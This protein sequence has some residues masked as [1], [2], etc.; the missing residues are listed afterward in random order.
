MKALVLSGG[1][2]TRLRPITSTGA[3]QLIPVANRPILFYVLDNVARAGLREVGMIISPETGNE[4]RRVVGSGERWGMNVEYILQDRPGGLAHAVKTA[5]PFLG[6]S[7]FVMYLGD[8]LIG[9]G[10]EAFIAKFESAGCA[11]VILLKEVEDA[12]WFGV[13]ELGPGG[14]VVRLLE[15]PRNPPSNLALVGVYVFSP[16]VHAAIDAIRP[17]ARG[18]LEITDAI[19]QLIDWNLPVESHVVEGWW[20]DTGKKDDLLAANTVVLDQWL[21]SDNQGELDSTSQVTGR[22]KI[23]KGSRLVNSRIRGPA[24][25]GEN[26]LIEDSFIGPYSSIGDGT[27]IRKSVVEHCVVLENCRID[28]IDRLE[29]SVLGK[30]VTVATN[31]GSHRALRLLLGDYSA[32]EL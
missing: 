17:S 32:V 28:S 26:V 10:I 27:R 7:P 16:Q 14:R 24:I 8:N 6:D 3:K 19:Q 4:I 20:L 23:G 9:T 11:A 12:R 13:A 22:V 5:R 21:K 31:H 30:N 2:G 15:K 29:D 18:E 25:V 1:Q